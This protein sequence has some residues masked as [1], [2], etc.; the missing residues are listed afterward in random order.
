[1]GNRQFIENGNQLKILISGATGL[2]GTALVG[3]LRQRGH[4]INILVRKKTGKPNEFMWSPKKNFIEDEAFQDI[5]C[6]IHL[7]GASVAKKWTKDYKQEI[8]N[9]RVEGANLLKRYCEKYNIHLK[10][11]ISASG[12]N[13]YGTF[14]SNKILTEIDG[15][16]HR[17]FLSK[18]CKEWENSANQFKEI[19]ER[20]V[21]VRIAPVLSK[22]GGT[23]APLN[24][25]ANLNLASGIGTGKQWFN[26]IHLEDLVNIFV[27]A[28]ENIAV[29]GV[30]NA[31]A[32]EVATNEGFMKALAKTKNKFF[33]PIKIPK[34]CIKFFLGE[35][36]EMILEGTRISNEKIK[37]EGFKFQFANLASALDDLLK[38]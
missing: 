3:K 17:D 8:I 19:S 24:K 37:S 12:I 13:Y 5:D 11:F 22:K 15:V 23:F 34:F 1:M 10:S 18:V 14:T 16:L 31:V 35:M 38:K 20:S 7:S 9:S 21:I 26:W 4:S 32:D 2:V 33:L 36:S 25:I 30:Y 28:V 27:N 29:N 6:I